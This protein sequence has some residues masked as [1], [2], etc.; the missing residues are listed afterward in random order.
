MLERA[1]SQGKPSFRLSYRPLLALSLVTRMNN[2]RSG[3]GGWR[4]NPQNL[5][6]EPAKSWFVCLSCVDQKNVIIGWAYFRCGMLRTDSGKDFHSA[7]RLHSP[8]Y[9]TSMESGWPT[10]VR[11]LVS[12]AN[13]H[14]SLAALSNLYKNAIAHLMD[15]ATITSVPQ[16]ANPFFRSVDRNWP[17]NISFSFRAPAITVPLFIES[18]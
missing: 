13:T 2:M 16:L 3:V 10:W 11:A 9:G 1:L 5:E 14:A 12:R 17:R 18:H 7:H 6:V 15:D 8:R 4:T